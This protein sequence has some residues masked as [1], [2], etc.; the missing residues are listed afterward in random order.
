MNT[1]Y[2]SYNLFQRMAYLLSPY[3]GIEP[4]KEKIEPQKQK[5]KI[6]NNGKRQNKIKENDV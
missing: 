3:E 2:I 5:K 4:Q 1:T 6:E